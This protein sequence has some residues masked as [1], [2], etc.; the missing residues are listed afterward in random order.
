MVTT[1]IKD[2]G[3]LIEVLESF[4]RRY[5]SGATVQQFCITDDAKM[6]DLSVPIQNA[7]ELEGESDEDGWPPVAAPTLVLW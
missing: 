3:D 4:R 5:G 1:K 6:L 2:I 7:T